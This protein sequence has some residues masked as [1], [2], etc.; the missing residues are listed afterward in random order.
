L[1]LWPDLLAALGAMAMVGA[2]V[3]AVGEIPSAAWAS[4]GKHVAWW[5]R[6][7]GCRVSFLGF[8][9]AMAAAAVFLPCSNGDYMYMIIPV[10][11]CAVMAALVAANPRLAQGRMFAYMPLT[12]CGLTA[13]VLLFI[14]IVSNAADGSSLDI[15][16][17]L[18]L[19]LVPCFVATVIQFVALADTHTR[20]GKA[21]VK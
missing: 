5:K 1:L 17:C 11:A 21:A 10:I 18:P 12:L 14:S 16:I 20:S 4:A 3:S 19:T 6:A 8:P 15:G 9:W 7:V 2:A 13:V